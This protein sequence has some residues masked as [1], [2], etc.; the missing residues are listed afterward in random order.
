MIKNQY[1]NIFSATLLLLYFSFFLPLA[2]QAQDGVLF[3]DDF[4]S[5]TLKPEWES[6]FCCQ[7]IENGWLHIKDID[8]WPRDSQVLVHDND[9]TWTD[10]RVSVTADFVN[11]T[12]WEHLNILLRTDRFK[13]SS[14]GSSGKAYQLDFI[15]SLGWGDGG[16]AI[17]LSRSD[18][19]L[20]EGD[21]NRYVELYRKAW[22]APHDPFAIEVILQGPQ[23]QLKINDQ[24]I[25]DVTD[26]NPLLF[27]GVGIHTIWESEA[28]IDNLVV[29][30]LSCEGVLPKLSA[31]VGNKTGVQS[32]RLWTIVL[33]NKSYC[34]AENA[35][36]DN[37]LLTQTTGTQCQPI[38]ASPLS[39]PLGIGNIPAGSQA[40]GTATIDFTG[41][42]N[43]ARF[44]ATIPFSSNNG[45][46]S[47]S[48]TLNNQ[49]R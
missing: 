35:Q 47:G 23:I 13:R 6:I 20:P 49:F 1:P 28:R 44:K 24:I 30:P 25:F 37:L 15:G 39:F 43:N 5:P 46:A 22:N 8:G 26:A 17:I 4:E 21:S 48:K 31:V 40:S 7:R 2:V 45:E 38:I 19:T 42:A 9:P 36:I 41:C 10:Y 29:S 16:K 11:G 34:P 14:G 18:L 27:G 3:Q 12:P 33:S 32:A